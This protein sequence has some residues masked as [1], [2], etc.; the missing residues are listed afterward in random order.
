MNVFRL[1]GIVPEVLSQPPRQVP[2]AG[3]KERYQNCASSYTKRLPE[4]RLNHRHKKSGEKERDGGEDYPLA[5][6]VLLPIILE[7]LIDDPIPAPPVAKTVRSLHGRVV[8]QAPKPLFPPDPG[9]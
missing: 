8:V 3:H 7:G 5:L 9:D 6:Q 4:W 2:D 1:V